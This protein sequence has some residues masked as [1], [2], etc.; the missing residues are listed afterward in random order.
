MQPDAPSAIPPDRQRFPEPALQPRTE[1][2]RVEQAVR[3][4]AE[5]AGRQRVEQ[6]ESRLEAPINPQLQPHPEPQPEAERDPGLDLN[7]LLLPR[8]GA[9][10]LL[11]VCGPSMAGAGLHDGDLLLVE[12]EIRPVPGQVVVAHLDGGFTV[13]RLMRH[14]AQLRL[15]AAHPAY[16]PLPLADGDQLWG[17]VRH[18]I[19][20]F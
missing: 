6:P 4:R 8:S 20:T 2:Q 15:E 19:H 9:A 10:V 14:G 3:Q 12:R 13:K 1:R 5:Q 16:P 17:V 7:A 18:V 11:R